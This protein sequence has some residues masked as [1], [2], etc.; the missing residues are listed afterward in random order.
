M[1]FCS[2]FFAIRKYL[3]P[4]MDSIRFFVRGPNGLHG[5][6]CVI[7]MDLLPLWETILFLVLGPKR[8]AFASVV[9]INTLLCS[10]SKWPGFRIRGWNQYAFVFFVQMFR[11]EMLL[12]TIL[13]CVRRP[14]GQAFAIDSML[15]NLEILTFRLL[16][17]LF[18]FS[19]TH[20]SIV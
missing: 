10:W 1:V 20:T 6:D 18:L 9:G 16:A 2:F 12:K 19:G 15:S 14:N 5:N 13:F 8:L 4:W 17:F 11:M 3:L 7:R